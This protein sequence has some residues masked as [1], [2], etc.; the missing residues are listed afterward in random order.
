[1]A[2]KASSPFQALFEPRRRIVREVLFLVAV[3]AV[4]VVAGIAAVWMLVTPLP[5]VYR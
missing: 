5:E 2:R 4:I 1:M 3:N